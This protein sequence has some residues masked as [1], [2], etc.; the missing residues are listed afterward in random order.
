MLDRPIEM[1]SADHQNKADTGLAIAR[2]WLDARGVTAI[3]DV[4]NS[5][6]ALAVNELVRSKKRIFLA[7]ATSDDLT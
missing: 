5:A 6:V 1:V 7:R 4:N 3:L 2:E